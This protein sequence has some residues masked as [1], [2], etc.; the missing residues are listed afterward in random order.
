MEQLMLPGTNRHDDS[1][2]LLAYH[3]AR[4]DFEEHL[5]LISTMLI[6]TIFWIRFGG[7]ICVPR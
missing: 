3:E 5:K 6:L 7:R 2:T 1:P 4:D